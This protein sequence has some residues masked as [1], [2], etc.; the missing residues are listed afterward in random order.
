MHAQA[1]RPVQ[2]AEAY[3]TSRRVVHASP[4]GSIPWDPSH[5]IH[6]V[7]IAVRHSALLRGSTAG[8][9]SRALP[10]LSSPSAH[11]ALDITDRA[12]AVLQPCCSRRNDG[13]AVSKLRRRAGTDPHPARS[14]LSR[15]SPVNLPWGPHFAASCSLPRV[16]K[17]HSSSPIRISSAASCSPSDQIHSSS[18]TR[19]S[20]ASSCSFWISAA[21]RRN[22]DMW[23]CCRIATCG[24]WDPDGSRFTRSG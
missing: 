22:D 11:C 21:R 18:P 12:A 7:R 24:T 15:E 23:T 10:P 2:W 14:R 17:N 13:A 19:I 8:L 20:S 5:G 4:V 3:S 9:C 6:P 16:R 1:V